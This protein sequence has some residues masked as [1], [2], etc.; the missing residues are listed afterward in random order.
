MQEVVTGW[1]LSF[2]R[3]PS[4]TASGGSRAGLL[5][6][7]TSG[8]LPE[9]DSLEGTPMDL[10]RD[11]VWG[12]SPRVGTAEDASAGD[13]GHRGRVGRTVLQERGTLPVSTFARF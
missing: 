5:Q 3:N 13:R 12:K 6:R 8:A 7:S 1:D 2:L 4:A 9:G 11:G 10:V